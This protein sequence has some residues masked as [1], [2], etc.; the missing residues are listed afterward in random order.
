MF[1]ENLTN[2]HYYTSKFFQALDSLLGVRHLATS[3]T[4]MCGYLGAPLH[5]GVRLSKSF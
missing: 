3:R 1:G 2:D 5:A 4:F